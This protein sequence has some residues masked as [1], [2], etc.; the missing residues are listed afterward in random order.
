MELTASYTLTFPSSKQ[1]VSDGTCKIDE[2]D[3]G[4]IDADVI[5]MSDIKGNTG[6]G[7]ASGICEIYDLLKE[8]QP[9]PEKV[10][11]YHSPIG[12][13]QEVLDEH[14]SMVTFNEDSEPDW[15]VLDKGKVMLLT[16]LDSL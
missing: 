2:Y 14:F 5:I 7:I 11:I 4:D 3:G 15:T 16:G 8:E 13:G 6:E 12:L 1:D 9:A 10:F